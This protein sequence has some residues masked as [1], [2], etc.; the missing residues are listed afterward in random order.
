MST[1]R[2]GL[3]SF[4]FAD[5]RQC[6]TPRCPGPP[7]S[8]LRD[9]DE[10]TAPVLPPIEAHEYQ[11]KR[12]TKGAFRNSFILKPGEIACSPQNILQTRNLMGCISKRLD[13]RIGDTVVGQGPQGRVGRV[14]PCFIRRV[15]ERGGEAALPH[16]SRCVGPC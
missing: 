7:Y 4:T 16:E 1:N 2:T 11:N 9:P 10:R 3:C 8:R 15:S 14:V 5:G 13:D 12:L 6:R